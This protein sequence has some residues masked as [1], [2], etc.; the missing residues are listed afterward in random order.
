MPCRP[1]SSP[2][3]STEASTATAPVA[4]VTA[5][6]TAALAASTRHRRGVA[7]SVRRIIPVLYS[8]LTTVTATIATMAWP[9][10]TPVRLI[11]AGSS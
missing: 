4:R 11:L 10:S 9:R 1:S 5:L 6:T 7:A 8:P 3:A 2:P